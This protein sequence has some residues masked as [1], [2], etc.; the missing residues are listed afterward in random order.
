MNLKLWRFDNCK[1][2]LNNTAV[3]S[4]FVFGAA[5]SADLRLEFINTTFQ[6]GNASQGITLSYGN[7]IWRGGS[8]G[9]SASPTTLLLGA[10]NISC[11]IEINC[12]DLSFLN[13]KTLLSL[14]TPELMHVYL[15]NCGLPATLTIFSGSIPGSNTRVWVDNCASNTNNYRMA[16]YAYQGNVQV[17]A[18]RYR[19]SGASDGTTNFCH[20]F[21]CPITGPSPF[22]PLEGPWMTIWNDVVGSSKTLTVEVAGDGTTWFDD[23]MWIEVEQLGVSAGPLGVLTNTRLV[24]GGTHQTLP[25]RFGSS[26][27]TWT[28]LTSPVPQ[29][30]TA[31]FT[32][33]IKG[34][35]RAR[36]L[37]C[38]PNVSAYVDPKLT[39]T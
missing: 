39:I 30:I 22:S 13:T 12:V 1:L 5:A 19:N 24:D 4:R 32:P 38:R 31:A 18:T 35:I 3:A 7:F 20:A 9:G 14:S 8:L 28:G 10:A 26:S 16:R 37:F 21:T 6:F 33:Q 36:V 34:I 29:R 25:A 2:V 23:D 27:A 11:V 15:R 17:D